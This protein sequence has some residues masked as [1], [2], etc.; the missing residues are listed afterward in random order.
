M[1]LRVM[2]SP[3]VLDQQVAFLGCDGEV[4][5]GGHVAVG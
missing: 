5:G 1:L 3:S 2:S 4:E